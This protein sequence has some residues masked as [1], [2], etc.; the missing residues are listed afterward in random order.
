MRTP[1][2]AV[3]F[4]L[5]LTAACATW[6]W[7]G[8]RASD[9]RAPTAALRGVAAEE[10]ARPAPR[11]D[12]SSEDAASLRLSTAPRAALPAPVPQAPSERERTSLF[13]SDIGPDTVDV[14]AYPAQQ[15]YNYAIFARDCSACH[16]LARSINAPLVGR[17]WWEFYMLGMRVRSRR[18]GRPLPPEETKAILDFLEYDSRARKVE[19]AREFDAL[20]EE[21]KRRFDRSVDERLRKLQ[22]R[23]RRLLPT[24]ER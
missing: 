11:V 12:A 17:G 20:T 2:L 15:R 22:K 4:V 21:L 24:G 19:G 9:G 18:A 5:V 1:R 23:G 7:S 14:S 13:Y 10:S 6:K 8:T 16:T 3:L